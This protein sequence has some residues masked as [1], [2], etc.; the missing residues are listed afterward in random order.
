MTRAGGLI[1]ALALCASWPAFSYRPFDGTDAAVAER[2]QLEIELGPIGLLREGPERFLVVPALIANVGIADHLELVLEGR[3]QF[4][5][6]EAAGAAR[7][8]LVDTALSLKAVVRPGELQE[9]SGPSVATEVGVLLPTL[10]GDPGVGAQATVIVSRRFSRAM[11]HLNG[12]VAFSRS[13]D[14]DLVSSVIVEGPPAWAVRPVFELFSEGQVAGAFAITG[15]AGVIWRYS[16]ALA[17]DAGVRA[18][19]AAG[20]TLIEGRLGLTFAVDLLARG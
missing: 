14:L 20:R 13:H 6:G 3:H 2:G 16:D 8:R 9:N 17:F 4:L 18:G 12:G 10:N 15:L 19:R 11:I 7:A 1:A 5:L